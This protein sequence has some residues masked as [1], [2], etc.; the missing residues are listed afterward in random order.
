MEL[1]SGT[2]HLSKRWRRQYPQHSIPVFEW[3]VA[4]GPQFDVTLKQ[5]QKFLRGLVAARK[6]AWVWMGTPCTSWSRARNI[7]GG[8]PP[9]RDSQSLMGKPNLKPHDV[10]KVRI[11][12]QT[13]RFSASLLNTCHLHRVPAVVENPHS[14]W[15]WSAPAMQSAARLRAASRVFT[16]Y[17]QYG[18]PWRNRTALLSVHCDVTPAVRRCQSP[19][20]K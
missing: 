2:G 16:D 11:G 13:M 14:S 15:L 17:C 12:N 19:G 4:F 9:L 18:Q 8:P 20:G 10:S 6:L 7:P 3:D 1:F 5:N